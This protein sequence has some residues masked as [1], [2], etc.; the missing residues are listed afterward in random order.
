MRGRETGLRGLRI[1][2]IKVRYEGN[3]KKTAGYRGGFRSFRLGEGRPGCMYG[4]G[5]DRRFL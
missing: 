3:E 5:S 2:N 4:H 1:G